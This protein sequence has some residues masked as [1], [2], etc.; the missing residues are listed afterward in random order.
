VPRKQPRFAAGAPAPT[1]LAYR[2]LP[3]DRSCLPVAGPCPDP[4][5]HSPSPSGGKKGKRCG[6][7]H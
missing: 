3:P 2:R 5:N 7:G 6:C 4:S 1:P